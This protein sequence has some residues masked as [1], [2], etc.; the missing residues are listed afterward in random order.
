MAR[1]LRLVY[2]MELS[3]SLLVLILD[4]GLVLGLRGFL[5]IWIISCGVL[6]MLCK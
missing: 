3:R 2:V 4:C 5:V 1:I 6:L